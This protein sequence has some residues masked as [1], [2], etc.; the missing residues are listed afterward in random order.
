MPKHKVYKFKSDGDSVAFLSYYEPKPEVGDIAE[1]V[2]KPTLEE[3]AELCDLHAEN[4]NY[5]DFVGVH[6]VLGFMLANEL[7]MTQATKIMRQIAQRG[8]LHRLNA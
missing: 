6:K 1:D 8:G 7:G 2:G 3:W 5:H 4:C